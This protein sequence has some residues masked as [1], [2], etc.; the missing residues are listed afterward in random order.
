MFL[1]AS[2]SSGSSLKKRARDGACVE[3]GPFRGWE[4]YRT[5]AAG[6]PGPSEWLRL[7]ADSM[8]CACQRGVR[9]MHRFGVVRSRL[10]EACTVGDATAVE[11]CVKEMVW[12]LPWKG[13]D[14]VELTAMVW[15]DLASYVPRL[16]TWAPDVACA[17]MRGTLR[18]MDVLARNTIPGARASA[19]TLVRL[20]GII[21]SDEECVAGVMRR[22]RTKMVLTAAGNDLVYALCTKHVGNRHVAEF[23]LWYSARCKPTW[24]ATALLALLAAV[25][26]KHSE[27]SVVNAYRSWFENSL[28]IRVDASTLTVHGAAALREAVLTFIAVESSPAL[29]LSFISQ[30]PQPESSYSAAHALALRWY[31][32]GVQLRRTWV[33]SV[34]A[35]TV[36]PDDGDEED[37][38]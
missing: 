26:W 35:S 18:V 19:D 6:A 4:E 29:W 15:E 2:G 38:D 9:C 24:R 25:C 3:G 33:A 1:V 32:P 17:L 28:A 11:R 27:T 22:W 7:T 12:L 36:V 16:E 23:A 8:P 37:M 34:T 13:C 20:L 5:T 21:G 14:D 30:C 10:K 31:H